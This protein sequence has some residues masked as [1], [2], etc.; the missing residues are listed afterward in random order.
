MSDATARRETIP[1]TIARNADV[2]GTI[3]DDA[4]ASRYP[5]LKVMARTAI[6]NGSVIDKIDFMKS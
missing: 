2:T 3:I 6:I 1:R 4:A 5:I